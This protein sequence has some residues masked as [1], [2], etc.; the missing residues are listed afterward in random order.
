MKSLI[1]TKAEFDALDEYSASLPT[2]TTVGKRWKRHHGAHDRA[3]I[4]GGGQPTWMIGEFVEIGHP[5][6]VGIEWYVPIIAV[7][8]SEMQSGRVV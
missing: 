4:A 5:T 2:G 8:G 6:A 3:F 1:L 7:P